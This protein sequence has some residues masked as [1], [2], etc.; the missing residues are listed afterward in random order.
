MLY[1]Y[2]QLVVTGIMI[3]GCMYLMQTA[4]NGRNLNAPN[5]IFF[6]CQLKAFYLYSGFFLSAVELLVRGE[7][8]MKI[9]SVL[10]TAVFN[11]DMRY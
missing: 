3:T 7:Q 9:A 4:K 8:K 11:T 5:H 10:C 6:F 1:I 2:T